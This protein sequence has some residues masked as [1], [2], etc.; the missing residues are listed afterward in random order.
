VRGVPPSLDRCELTHKRR[1]P[2]DLARAVGQH[3]AYVELL[4]GLGLE[5][6]EL[7][8]DPAHPDCCFVEDTAVVLDDVALV[9]M[10]GAPS[11]RGETEAVASA[12]EQLLSVERMSLP[13]TLDGGDVLRVAR[14][15]YVGRSSRTN[16]AGLDRLSEA[17]EPRGFRVV[18]V[19]VQECLHLKS[20][21]STL[22]DRT[23]L[24]NPALVDTAALAGLEV[25]PV[26]AQEPAAANVLRVRGAVVADPAFPRTLER[27]RD[28][29]YDVRT[30]DVSE[31]RKAEG[32]LT[33]KSLL[34]RRRA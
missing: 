17:A 5:V 31:F 16:A 3:R 30:L 2:I 27:L 25:V 19:P 23:V 11:R 6:V 12:L 15:L 7:P 24:A 1:E 28:R 34:L 9:T 32:A 18:G 4:R 8:A 20:A 14:T 13:A 21:V 10:P 22:D 29:G 33:C 26:H